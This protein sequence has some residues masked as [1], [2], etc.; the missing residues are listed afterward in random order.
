[1]RGA[2]L[3]LT[4]TLSPALGWTAGVWLGTVSAHRTVRP[5]TAAPSQAVA[6]ALV[7]DATSL[8]HDDATPA[9]ATYSRDDEGDLYEWHSPQTELARLREPVG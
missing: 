7:P 5:S 3:V 9:V 2:T 4:L 1:M 8:M 6:T